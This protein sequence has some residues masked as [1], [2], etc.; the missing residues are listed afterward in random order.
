MFKILI[1]LLMVFGVFAPIEMLAYAQEA[2]EAVVE[3]PW[4]KSKEILIGMALFLSEAIALSPLK[5]NSIFQ[6]VWN[7]LK[8]LKPAK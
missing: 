5:S 3:V 8:M 6:F 1:A 4:Y 2:A 7:I